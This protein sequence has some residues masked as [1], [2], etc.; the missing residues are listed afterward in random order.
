MPAVNEKK[1][2]VPAVGLINGGDVASTLPNL[3]SFDF[4][5]ALRAG[6]AAHV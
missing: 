4:S 5:A 2:T 6:E 3:I 1:T